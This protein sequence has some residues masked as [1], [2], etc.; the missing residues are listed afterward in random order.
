MPSERGVLSGAMDKPSV[1]VKGL[2][3]SRMGSMRGLKGGASSQ[4]QSGSLLKSDLNVEEA[5]LSENV[6]DRIG[7]IHH[8]VEEKSLVV[9]AK[10]IRSGKMTSS[11][12][13]W[14]RQR[15]RWRTA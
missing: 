4:Q 14:R 9:H 11:P 6:L 3:A 8:I 15:G 5:L 10:Q 13:R 2:W 1:G 12:R 7:G